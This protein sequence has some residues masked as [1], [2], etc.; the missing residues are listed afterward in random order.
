MTQ[1]FGSAHT[2]LKLDKLEE[3]L[4]IYVTALKN[5]NFDLIYFDAFAGAG[6]IQIGSDATL[7]DSVDDYSPFIKGSAERA[8]HFK[9]SFSRYIFVD[10]KAANV[11]A[12]QRLRLEHRDIAGRIDVRKGDANAELISF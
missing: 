12:L 4:R 10:R 11:R 2:K 7:L 1:R 6:D 9:E 5:Q 3:Y 8:L